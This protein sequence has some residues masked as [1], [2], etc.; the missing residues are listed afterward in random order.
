MLPEHANMDGENTA[1]HHRLHCALLRYPAYPTDTYL[2]RYPT[3]LGL[4]PREVGTRWAGYPGMWVPR[5]VGTQVWEPVPA[6]CEQHSHSVQPRRAACDWSSSP[7]L[8]SPGTQVPQS[9]EALRIAPRRRIWS[10]GRWFWAASCHTRQL[11]VL[12]WGLANPRPTSTAEQPPK[13]AQPLNQP[14]KGSFVIA[15]PGVWG[16]P[17]IPQSENH[18]YQLCG[19]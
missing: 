14:A 11:I 7:L 15:Q 10:V 6:P 3:P 1:P 16:T 2:R 5:G 18:Y 17:M 8:S 4:I 13:V 9:E 12:R 19:T